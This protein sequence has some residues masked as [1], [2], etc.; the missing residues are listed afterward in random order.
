MQSFC[1]GKCIVLYP[2]M[3]GWPNTVLESI[4][5][6]GILHCICWSYVGDVVANKCKY[7]MEDDC[8]HCLGGD[9]P[10][11]GQLCTQFHNDWT[12][13]EFYF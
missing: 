5:N 3:C 8:Y 4:I 6:H 2:T 10:Q 7:I 1:L 11:Y 12:G 9:T 13:L